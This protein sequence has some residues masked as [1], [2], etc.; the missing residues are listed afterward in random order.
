MER[1]VTIVL[2]QPP[3]LIDGTSRVQRDK[4]PVNGGRG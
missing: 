1:P 4:V 3:H 2:I